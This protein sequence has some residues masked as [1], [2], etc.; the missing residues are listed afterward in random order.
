MESAAGPITVS[1][2]KKNN[3]SMFLF[4]SFARAYILFFVFLSPNMLQMKKLIRGL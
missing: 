1:I 3:Q 4:A 2:K